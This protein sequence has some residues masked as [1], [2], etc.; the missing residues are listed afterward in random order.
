V[1]RLDLTPELVTKLGSAGF[2]SKFVDAVREVNLEKGYVK[3]YLLMDCL[4][5]KRFVKDILLYAPIAKEH[6]AGGLQGFAVRYL[7]VVTS[8]ARGVAGIIDD[9]VLE[10]LDK[11]AL[12]P[13]LRELAENV[14]QNI[15]YAIANELA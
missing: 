1:R 11:C 6:L 8:S 5:R 12:G 13:E 2:I 3:G 14:F 4:A 9:D 10:A 15:E 7:L